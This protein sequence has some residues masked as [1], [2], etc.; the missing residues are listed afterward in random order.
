MNTALCIQ[1]CFMRNFRIL[2]AAKTDLL[3]V[4]LYLSNPHAAPGVP[5]NAKK[6]ALVIRSRNALIFGVDLIVRFSKIM[7]SVVEFISVSVINDIGRPSVKDIQDDKTMRQ[8]VNSI[9]GYFPVTLTVHAASLLSNKTLVCF[10]RIKPI[11]VPALRLIPEKGAKTLR[12]KIGSS[13]EAPCML[14]GQRPATI[15]SRS[16]ASSFSFIASSNARRT[17]LEACTAPI[18]PSE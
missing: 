16:R 18:T 10:P 15:R 13:H 6:T 3:T 14:I 9:N 17:A 5:R 11:E 1:V 4:Y 8:M 2:E 7:K 12:C